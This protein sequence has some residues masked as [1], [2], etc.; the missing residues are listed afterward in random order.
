MIEASAGWWLFAAGCCLLLPQKA[1]P[2]LV[3]AMALHETGH[4]LTILLMRGRIERVRFGLAG[5][6]I[7]VAG[8]G[9]QQEALAAL[10]GPVCSIAGFAVLRQSF[11]ECAAFSLSLG[12]FNLLPL[13][14]LDGGRA[15]RCALL[16]RLP[17]EKAEKISAAVGNGCGAA[18]I[19]GAA[20]TAVLLGSDMT[21]YLC[22]GS[23][24][25]R[26]FLLENRQRKVAIFARRR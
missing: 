13:F 9:Y 1:L 10:A 14:P 2:E 17:P 5:I 25:A 23:L 7:E 8:L 20:L 15:L 21:A 12:I 4:V 22:A 16:L 24:L 18:L 26:L 3:A 11:S 19:A 6:R